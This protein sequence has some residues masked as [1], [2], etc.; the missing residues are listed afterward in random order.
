MSAT[1]GKFFFFLIL[2]KCHNVHLPFKTFTRIDCL[3]ILESQ[4]P[5]TPRTRAGL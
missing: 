4:P 1:S 5:G 2:V 3:E